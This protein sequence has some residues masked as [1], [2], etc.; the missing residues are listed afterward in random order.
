MGTIETLSARRGYAVNSAGTAAGA[1][2]GNSSSSTGFLAISY[3]SGVM[4]EV[5]NLADLPAVSEALGINSSGQ[6]VGLART[7]PAWPL[8]SSGSGPWN[9]QSFFYDGSSIHYLPIAGP[10]M[11]R[12]INDSGTIVGI[13]SP[14]CSGFC[15]HAYSYSGSTLT[16]L[17]PSSVFGVADSI[18][19]GGVVVGLFGTNAGAAHLFEYSGSTLTDLGTPTTNTNPIEP[20][21]IDNS[22]NIALSDGTTAYYYASSTYN[23]IP[24]LSGDSQSFARS[25]DA[26]T[27][28]GYSLPSGHPWQ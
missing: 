27:V 11:A 18:N 10:S 24:F 15:A 19:A 26:G 16:D 8:G 23:S 2:A 22:N 4:T 14:A 1:V 13:F 21:S 5:P 7:L 25:I 3:S 28:V 6:I 20:V 17:T 9:A 12:A